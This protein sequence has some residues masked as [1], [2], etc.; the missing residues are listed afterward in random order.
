MNLLLSWLIIYL[1]LISI[2]FWLFYKALKSGE[3]RY[4]YMIIFISIL[5]VILTF[6][7]I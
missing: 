1:I 6:I 2:L 3:K 7:P 4:R 5:M